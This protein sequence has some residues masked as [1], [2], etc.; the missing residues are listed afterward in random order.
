MNMLTAASFQQAQQAQA[1]SNFPNTIFA[2][3][4]NAQQLAGAVTLG[5]QLPQQSL[6]QQFQ[7]QL[8]QN[9]PNQLQPGQQQQAISYVNQQQPGP[10]QQQQ[11]QSF[12]QQSQPPPPMSNPVRK[13]KG[14]KP[15]D[16][17]FDKSVVFIVNYITYSFVLNH[18]IYCIWIQRYDFLYKHKILQSEKSACCRS[19]TGQVQRDRGEISHSQI[20]LRYV[21][22][23]NTV[24]CHVFKKKSQ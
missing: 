15:D 8:Q 20:W 9:G 21:M 22:T 17:W 3:S 5:G 12:N 14:K 11:Q 1:G 18:L 24:E 13:I 2:P 6:P 10:S 16:E 7:V 23:R 4:L 19:A